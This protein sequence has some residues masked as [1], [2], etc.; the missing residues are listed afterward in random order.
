MSENRLKVLVT[1]DE[2]IVRDFFKR[3]MSLFGLEV[4]EAPDGFSAIEMARNNKFDLFFV[5][6]RMP[7][8]DG[9]E[10]FRKIKEID[11]QAVVVM[12]TGY[13][14]EQ[15]LNQAQKEGAYG[16]IRKPFDISQI[17]DVVEKF[18]KPGVKLPSNVLVVDDDETILNF[19][20]RFLKGKN[21]NY[22]AARNKKEALEISAGEK[23]DL[24]FLDLVVGEESGIEIYGELRKISP[25]VEIVLMSGYH[26]KA[27]E[28][29][30][31][32]ELAGCLYKPF[33]IESIIKYIEQA[34]ARK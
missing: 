18:N 16:I 21:V 9:L 28:L 24:V 3:L 12:I 8:L 15:A 5:D 7:G 29:E 34:K 25:L 31:E 23:F 20:T 14:V 4:F 27:K 6:V 32:I 19:F 22:K 1:D 17:K 33:D 30:K 10:T 11:P 13:A 2:K 26:Q